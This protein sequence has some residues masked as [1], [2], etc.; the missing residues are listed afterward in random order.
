MSSLVRKSGVAISL[1]LM[2]CGSAKAAD[3]FYFRLRPSVSILNQEAFTIKIE[4]DRAGVVGSSFIAKAKAS[5]PRE[6]LRF[7]VS[8]GDLPLGVTLDSTSGNISGHPLFKGR[9][10]ATLKAEDAFSSASAP[11]EVQ[12]YDALEISSLIPTYATVGH[13]YSASFA[14]NGGNQNFTWS[15]NKQPPTGLSFAGLPS[16]TST[17]S[18]I[19]TTPG[20][21][22]DLQVSLSDSAG[23][24]I[25]TSPF[26]IAV[27][28]PLEIS[29]VPSEVATVGAPYSAS[30]WSTGG[31]APLS[32]SIASGIL[33]KGL[34][35]NNGTI[36][37]TPENPGISTDLVVRVTDKAAN[38]VDFKRFSIAVSQ[39]LA[40]TGTPSGVATVGTPYSTSFAPAGGNGHYDWVIKNGNLPEGLILVNGTISG[41][42]IKAETQNGISVGIT[43]SDGRIAQSDVFSIIVLDP[44]ELKGIPTKAATVGTDYSFKFNATGGNN[45]YSWSVVQGTL[46][47]GLSLS[48]GVIS[49]RP[50]KANT[51]ESIIVEVSDTDGRK[52][53]SKP[54]TIIVSDE[55]KLTG[56]PIHFATVS[57]Q[58]STIFTVSGGNGTN[59]WKVFS[60]KLPPGLSLS[61]GVISGV[62]TEAKSFDNIIIEVSDTDGRSKKS[63]S[64]SITVSDVLKVSVSTPNYG[65]VDV[66]YSGSYTI[67]GGNGT[68]KLEV[69]GRSLPTG[70]TASNGI[71]SGTP[72]KPEAASNLVFRVSDSDG[73]SYD[74]QAFSIVISNPISISVS[75]PNSGTVGVPYSGSYTIT[76]GNGNNTIEVVGGT[77]PSGLALSNG[78]I[79]GSPNSIA[80]ASNIAIRAVDTNGRSKTSDPFSIFVSNPLIISGAISTS[81]KTNQAFSS[82]LLASGGRAPFK[83]ENIGSTLPY[84]LSLNSGVVSGIPTTAATFSNIV[85]R[86]TDADGRSKQYG[87]IS[88]TIDQTTIR[89][90][91]SGSYYQQ[92]TYAY[93]Y[94]NNVVEFWWNGRMV[95]GNNTGTLTMKAGGATYYAV[96]PQ[97]SSGYGFFMRIYRTIP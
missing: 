81:G 82:T 38:T 75:T 12:V 57:Q 19:P 11:L 87:P 48:N 74:S 59:D 52:R 22:G 39:P 9:F 4:G 53:R 2:M 24:S 35:F 46:P 20:L 16:P 34:Q 26:S 84:G 91:A 45:N 77:L 58:Y 33:P 36:S 17:I 43:D 68:N 76:G 83:W 23:H 95:A 66:P 10:K 89:E 41:T 7:S 51:Y 14:G 56:N 8:E 30:F 3:T 94:Y 90:P 49:G 86:V 42:P 27:A 93:Y 97:D 64:F 44:I 32:W 70:L 61:N 50:T 29:G 6:T 88:I 69:V 5:S 79:S 80:T 54:F 62:P 18:G 1:A 21:W 96:T 60:G 72:S 92:G 65:T 71:I 73:R 31:H 63:N 40:L 47:E 55:L 13:F 15:L 25:S 85:I 67:T 78:K 37:G 28:N